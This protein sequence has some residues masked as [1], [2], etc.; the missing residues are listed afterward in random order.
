ML[1]YILFEVSSI[2]DI[3]HKGLSG[4]GSICLVSICLLGIGRF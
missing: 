1:V 3:T 4:L 2:G